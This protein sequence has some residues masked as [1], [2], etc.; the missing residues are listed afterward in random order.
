V[1]RANFSLGTA[2]EKRECKKVTAGGS[3][4]EVV[5]E[6]QADGYEKNSMC[7][8][9][10]NPPARPVDGP[11][12]ELMKEKRVL[13]VGDE[14]YAAAGEGKDAGAPACSC[15]RAACPLVPKT[16][17]Y[18][19]NPDLEALRRRMKSVEDG[20]ASLGQSGVRLELQDLKNFLTKIKDDVETGINR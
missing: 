13:V 19:E 3:Y 15:S 16:L 18:P 5:S 2:R 14:K 4:A 17:P 10:N 6:T 11:K 7:S 12:A 8:R 20:S 9:D 1:S